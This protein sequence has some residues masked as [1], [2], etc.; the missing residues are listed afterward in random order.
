MLRSTSRLLTSLLLLILVNSHTVLANDKQAPK[1]IRVAMGNFEPY[2]IQ[3]N[4]SGIFTELIDAV[5]SKM[6]NYKTQYLFGYSNSR[7]WHDFE[8]SKIDAV[9]NLIDSVKI[10]ACRSD[11]IFRFRDVVISK[12]SSN[13]QIRRISDLADKRIVT[14]QGAKGFLGEEFSNMIKPE[15][16]QEVAEQNWQAKV[17]FS[18]QADLSI[19]DMFTFLYSIKKMKKIPAKASD[20]VF[21]DLFPPIYSRMGFHDKVLCERFNQALRTI[22]KNGEYEGIYDKYLKSFK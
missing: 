14:F 6:P 12:A 18:G 3:K 9:S 2:F 15:N 20:F 1:T 10:A 11:K 19:G 13:F 7:A 5:F 17:L 8:Q 21:H 16:Y 4:Q 22:K